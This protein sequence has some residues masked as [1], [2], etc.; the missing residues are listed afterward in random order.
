MK[1][2]LRN[3]IHVLLTLGF[4]GLGAVGFIILTAQKPQLKKTAPEVPVPTVRTVTVTTDTLSVPVG[5]E[6]TVRPLRQ[7]QLIPEVSGKLVFVAD[8]LVA[9]GAF[10]NGQ[11]LLKIDPLDYELA[12]TLARARVKDSESALKLIQEEAA[13]SLEEWRLLNSDSPDTAG[14][15]PALVAKEPQLAAAQAKL[16]ADR[17][18]LQKAQLNLQ[19]TRIKAPFN[20]RVSDENVDIGQ[21]VAAGQ[22]LATLFSSEAAEIILPLEDESLRWFHVPGFTPGDG[23]GSQ[24]SVSARIAGRD[25]VWQGRVV[26]A[27]A[28]LDAGTRLINVIVQVDDPYAGKPPLAAGLFVKVEIE[29]RQLEN[30]VIAPRSILRKNDTVWVVDKDGRLWFRPVTVARLLPKSVI[31]SDGL[32]MNERV[33]ISPLKA[34]T[35]GMQVRVE[36]PA[37]ETAS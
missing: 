31:V 28:Q 33:V 20:G 2:I 10:E 29:G 3:T 30:A 36:N 25:R 1:P 32:E 37:E 26:R 6:G 7:I 35:D 21:Y 22:A 18:D 12:V 4:I 11:T 14:Q 17:A 24:A 15:P 19:R 34:V 23:P 8:A 5:G 16:E 13:A 27:E 9:G